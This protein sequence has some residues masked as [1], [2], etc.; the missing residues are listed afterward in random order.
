MAESAPDNLTA[1]TR[2]SVYIIAL[3]EETNIGRALASVSWADEVVVLDSGS[4]DRTAGIAREHGAMVVTRLFEGYADQKNHAMDHCTGD[5]LFNMDAD[6]E[7]TP[8]L[9]DSIRRT[10]SDGTGP[11]AYEVTRRTWYLGRWI[12][13]CGWYP[14]YRRRLSR[15][16]AARWHGDMVHEC[17]EGDGPVGRLAGDLN[18]RPYRD[19]GDHL[20]TI[21]RYSALFAEREYRRGRRPSLA[22]AAL[23]PIGRF[24]KMY[25]LRGGFLDRGP[26]FIASVMGAWYT[27]MK[28]ARLYERARGS[29]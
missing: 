4:T 23:R 12:R 8:E 3:N 14:E 22:E 20:K 6:E 5:W 19:L 26:G 9:A 24:L 7:V 13:H 27:F 11:A 29:R 1:H 15:K 18:H 10:V 28:Y 21:D 2:L 16:N 25:V 17:L